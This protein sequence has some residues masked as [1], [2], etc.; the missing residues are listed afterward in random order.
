[1]IS[2]GGRK[3]FTDADDTIEGLFLENG[4]SLWAMPTEAE[5]AAEVAFRRQGCVKG[6]GEWS[7]DTPGFGGVFKLAAPPLP[8]IPRTHA[9]T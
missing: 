1:M 4:N 7:G 5:G 3:N 9:R 2:E 8:L 6:M